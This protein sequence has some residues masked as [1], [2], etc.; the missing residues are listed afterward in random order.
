MASH[1]KKARN[2]QEEWENLAAEYR[3]L[4]KRANQR[5]VRIE[6]Y[7]ERPGY[8]ALLEYAYKGAQQDIAVL[9]QKE[10]TKLRY[11]E[12]ARQTEVKRDGEVLTGNEAIKANIS[13]IKSRIAS[14]EHFLNA[15]TSTV[16]DIKV[17]GEVV[18]SGYLSSQDKRADTLNKHLKENYKY[19][20]NLSAKDLQRFFAS[21]KQQK[22]Q[23]AVGS[24]MMFVVVS[25]FRDRKIASNKRD[26]EKFFR[27]NINMDDL[28]D[29][30]SMDPKKYSSYKDYWDH[31]SQF[32]ELT[33]DKMLDSYVTKAIKEGLNY[34]NI[35][36]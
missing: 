4:A 11:T 18:K 26:L 21:K 29:G 35:F 13:M 15:K 22:L 16:A 34:K 14:M 17:N 36:I 8:K 2:W 1:S 32:V 33:G 3:K 28:P 19:T 5:M 27:D 6:R 24:D 10:G 9:Y 12:T 31:L 25:V 7:A 30:V 23:D 20:A